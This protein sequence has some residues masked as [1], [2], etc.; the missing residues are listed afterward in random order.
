MPDD[1]HVHLR[2]DDM[3]AA[4]VEHT[5][6]WFRYGMVM[7][8][9]RPPVQT[10]AQAD[11]YRRRILN[12]VPAA[13]SHFQP[14]MTL[15]VSHD[16]DLDDLGRGIEAGI[17]KAVK[18][19][20]PG[21]TTN[22]DQAKGDLGEFDELF[23][24]LVEWNTQLLVHAESTRPD[25]DLFD[26]E[27]A[28]LDD[29]LAGVCARH[30]KLGVT[31][32]HVSTAAG[33][34]F[35]RSNANVVASITPH[36]L[37]RERADL[38]AFGMKP[39]LYCKPVLNTAADRDALVRA[40]VSG[41]G[42]FFLGTDSAPHPTTAKYGPN[43][44]AGVFNA[45]YGLEVVAEVFHQ[46]AALEQLGKFV[47]L[48]GAAVYGVPPSPAQLRLTRHEAQDAVPERLRTNSGEEVVFF[49]VEEARLWRV[50]AVA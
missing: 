41:D 5:A 33:V 7:P 44:A 10:T 45:P 47:S 35:V 17:V 38:L 39:D 18:F 26:R 14:Q 4:V 22:S 2:D 21:A 40:A 43:V 48:N 50:E 9:L 34:E 16:L 6:R 8:N 19:Y 42:Q 25:V 15:F 30:P 31:L 37:S 23:G 36:H 11:A 12:H 20:P 28:F 32:E 49:G 29:H 3:L 1:W 46:Q 13:S 27:A 24:R